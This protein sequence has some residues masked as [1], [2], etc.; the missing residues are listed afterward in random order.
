MKSNAFFATPPK[1]ERAILSG[2]QADGQS[3]CGIRIEME[4]LSFSDP[5]FDRQLEPEILLEQLSL[6][7]IDPAKL[8]N[9]RHSPDYRYEASVYFHDTHNWVD[10]EE[11][12]FLNATGNSILAEYDLVIHLPTSSEPDTYPLTIRVPTEIKSGEPKLE[13]PR[14]VEGLGTLVQNEEDM[15]KGNATYDGH[16]VEI[17]FS[18]D[19]TSFDEIAIYARSV[20]AGESLPRRKMDHEIAQGLRFLED[21]FRQFN[22]SQELKAEEFVPRSFYFYKRRHHDHPEVMIS[23]DHPADIGHWSLTFHRLD[24]GD[25]YW[26]PKQ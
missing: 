17:E 22:I 11:I 21:K 2:H 12:R 9:T 1:A 18:A 14:A 10:V 5:D 24:S 3:W 7:S 15:W 13:A 8:E 4:P 26:G 23:L 19:A 16:K 20:L 25:L 6:P